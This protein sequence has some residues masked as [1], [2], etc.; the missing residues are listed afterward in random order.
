MP[1]GTT[2]LV[3]VLFAAAGVLDGYEMTAYPAVR[4]EADARQDEL[5]APQRLVVL[6]QVDLR[7]QDLHLAVRGVE[8]IDHGHDIVV[9]HVVGEE[10]EYP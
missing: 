3:G 8:P 9:R 1:L 10:D 7:V 4:A 5:R 6:V 2:G